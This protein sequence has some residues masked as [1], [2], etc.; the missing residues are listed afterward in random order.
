M[1]F[2]VL[3]ENLNPIERAVFLLREVF[4]YDYAEI[5][6]IVGK[7]EANCR[8]LARRARQHINA[9][10]P[11]FDPSPEQQQRLVGQF[12]ETCANGDMPGLLNLLADDIVFWSDGGG[13]AIA[14]VKPIHGAA[15]VARFM[16]GITRNRPAN[17]AIRTAWVNGQPGI[18]GYE[19]GYPTTVFVFEIFDGRIQMVHGIRNPDKLQGVP[20]LTT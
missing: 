15:K 14:A 19:D 2:L 16:L 4:D 13:K 10:R 7:S 5:A 3:L 1:G 8:Q 12:M 6:R 18:I 11:R 17:F 20:R 9:R